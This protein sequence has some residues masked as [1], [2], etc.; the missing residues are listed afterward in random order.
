VTKTT[1]F[2][3]IF[4]NSKMLVG[5]HFFK[6]HLVTYKIQKEK[7]KMLRING[8]IFIIKLMTGNNVFFSIISI[9][10]FNSYRLCRLKNLLFTF[11]E[12]LENYVREKISFTIL[13]TTVQ[14]ILTQNQCLLGNRLE[15]LNNIFLFLTKLI[16]SV[17]FHK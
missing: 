10:F 4:L 7:V 1:K 5:K 17:E 11:N 16:N 9:Y 8:L 15:V 2:W 14:T 12:E 13:A 3:W 6:M